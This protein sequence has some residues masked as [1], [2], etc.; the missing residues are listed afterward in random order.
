MYVTSEFFFRF[1][2]EVNFLGREC[3]QELAAV[4]FPD[5]QY[6]FIQL[7]FCFVSLNCILLCFFQFSGILIVDRPELLGFFRCQIEF[8]GNECDFKD[9]DTV[10]I[11]GGAE[12]NGEKAESFASGNCL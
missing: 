1:E 7:D 12:K 5:V 10:S 6:G 11:L 8:F 2:E 3:R 9:F 4:F